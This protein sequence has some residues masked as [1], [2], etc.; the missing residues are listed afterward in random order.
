[1]VLPRGSARS[2]TPADACHTTIFHVI[3]IQ[4]VLIKV[5]PA[6]ATSVEF[7]S[8]F[9]FGVNKPLFSSA[10][11]LSPKCKQPKGEAAA[12]LNLSVSRRGGKKQ[13]RKLCRKK[14]RKRGEGGMLGLPLSK[15]NV[16]CGEGKLVGINLSFP[17]DPPP[18]QK[19]G[20]NFFLLLLYRVV[21][22]ERGCGACPK[23]AY[24]SF[25]DHVFVR[26]VWN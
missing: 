22:S 19:E 8:H 4:N 3:C 14:E 11:S 26:R 16:E 5:L 13:R 20:G 10:L 9:L 25:Q 12:M 17:R 23:S 15:K 1:M 7:S 2:L 24:L 6:L 18:P 21:R